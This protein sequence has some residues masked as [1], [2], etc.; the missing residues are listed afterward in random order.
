M[1]IIN[2]IVSKDNLLKVTFTEDNSKEEIIPIEERKEGK[3]WFKSTILFD[4]NDILFDIEEDT[5]CFN[6]L[7]DLMENPNE[8]KE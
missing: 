7:K 5:N 6:P 1:T 3:E 4:N 2:I 8:L